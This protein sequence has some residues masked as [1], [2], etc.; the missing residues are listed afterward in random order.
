MPRTVFGQIMMMAAGLALAISAI[1][2]AMILLLPPP[3]PGRINVEEMEWALRGK[4]SSVIDLKREDRPPSGLRSSLV[5]AALAEAL[6]RY[7]REIRAVWL[8]RPGEIGDTR[9]SVVLINEQ[10][11]VIKRGPRGWNLRTGREAQLRP[12][13]FVP[14]FVAAVLTDDG[15]WVWGVPRD[16]AK[17]EWQWRLLIGL[18]AVA[19]IVLVLCWIMSRKLAAPLEALSNAALAARLSDDAPY[20]VDGPRET[21]VAG[22][23]MNTMHAHL[24][25]AANERLTTA[26]AV[27]HDI[28]TPVTALRLRAESLSEPLRTKMTDDLGRVSVLIQQLLDYSR[29]SSSEVILE[30]IDL[31]DLATQI[32]DRRQDLGQDVRV[33][34]CEKVIIPT[35]AALLTRA[36]DNLLDNA[37]KFGTHADISVGRDEGWSAFTVTDDGPGI[38]EADIAVAVRPFVR[39]DPSR[40]DRSGGAGLGLAI[41]ST[42]AEVLGAEFVIANV[43]SGLKAEIRWA[44]SEAYQIHHLRD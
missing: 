37:L 35:D 38:D 13:T 18:L 19:A 12:E 23:A 4:Q 21:E 26:A 29:M 31:A 32:C 8:Q 5:E 39:L 1:F 20:P 28:G 25:S 24:Q 14:L 40:S 41:V 17:S 22:R 36:I 2:T 16:P 11:A 42:I 43:A 44:T 9:Q 30:P 34:D 6:G 3:A 27:A 7:P 15:D 33:A 10:D